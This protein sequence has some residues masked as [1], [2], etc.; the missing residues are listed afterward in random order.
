[1]TTG[2]DTGQPRQR[3]PRGTGDRL[4]D[5]LIDAAV[6][7]LAAR[8]DTERLSIRA[9]AAEA[10]VSPPAVYLHFPD[11]RGLVRAAVESCFDRDPARPS[12]P[13]HRHPIRGTAPPVPGLCRVRHRP[14]PPVPGNV[15]RLVSRAPHSAA[16]R[17]LTSRG[18]APARAPGGLGEGRLCQAAHGCDAVAG[19]VCW[20]TSW[21]PSGSRRT[22][23]VAHGCCMGGWSKSAPRA[24]SRW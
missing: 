12:R 6:R 18:G 13:R 16:A 22:A 24:W 1:M 21:L 19:Q 2:A 15:R 11:R 3:N 9:V 4:R 17:G 8:G 10:Q 14:A 20:R 5:E 23:S 7:V